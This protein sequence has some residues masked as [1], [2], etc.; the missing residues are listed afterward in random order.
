MLSSP[1]NPP[2]DQT[3]TITPAQIHNLRLHRRNHPLPR[4]RPRRQESHDQ[5]A[6]L[7]M[8]YL[9]GAESRMGAFSALGGRRQRLY[10]QRYLCRHRCDYGLGW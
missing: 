2:K 4:R 6:R 1:Q 8:G 5:Q 7:A 9:D 3:L 10:F